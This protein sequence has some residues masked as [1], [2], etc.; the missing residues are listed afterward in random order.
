MIPN[1]PSAFVSPTTPRAPMNFYSSIAIPW[2]D[3]DPGC[4]T[5]LPCSRD[6]FTAPDKPLTYIDGKAVI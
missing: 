4:V 1:F 3:L 5:C 6:S 2:D